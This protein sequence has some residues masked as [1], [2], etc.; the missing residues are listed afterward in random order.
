M[1]FRHRSQ[2]ALLPLELQEKI[3]KTKSQCTYFSE[4]D[5]PSSH[6]QGPL[7]INNIII[8]KAVALLGLPIPTCII[9]PIQHRLEFVCEKNGVIF[10]ND[11]K[12]T[13]PT[14]T[15]KALQTLEKKSVILILGGLSK[16]ID[17]SELC[18]FICNRYKQTIK[19]IIC[20]GAESETLKKYCS[21]YNLP[22]MST[23]NLVDAIVATKTNAQ[24][25]D[26]ILFSPSGSSYDLFKNYEER[27]NSFKALIHQLM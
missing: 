8:S 4:Y 21:D 3:G 27:G 2:Y 1:I 23:P 20:F 11:S 13:T 5:S 19:L 16:G 7:T 24:K 6:I 26:H 14:S 17:R 25:G 22:V 9:P 12:S 18:R 15:L 10:I